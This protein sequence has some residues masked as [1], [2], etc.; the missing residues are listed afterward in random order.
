MLFQDVLNSFIDQINSEQGSHRP[1]AD[2][3][4]GVDTWEV[5]LSAQN[6]VPCVRW[7]AIGITA[8]SL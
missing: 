7:P 2:S 1:A 6:V 3:A 5:I 4:P 8:F